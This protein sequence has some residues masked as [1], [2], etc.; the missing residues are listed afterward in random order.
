MSPL[1]LLNKNKEGIRY[2][3]YFF[4]RMKYAGNGRGIS[5]GIPA[6]LIID[7]KWDQEHY[8]DNYLTVSSDGRAKIE[9]MVALYEANDNKLGSKDRATLKE[10]KR[11]L[12]ESK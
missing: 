3:D 1:K 4:E 5:K 9:E 7:P 12:E 2:V 6:Q 8:Y 11:D 10:W